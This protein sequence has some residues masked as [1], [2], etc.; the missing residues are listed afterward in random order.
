MTINVFSFFL[1]LYR[2]SFLQ[3]GSF[4]VCLYIILSSLI[5]VTFSLGF[6]WACHMFSLLCRIN[7]TKKQRKV[8]KA[9]SCRINI[10][11]DTS[12]SQSI[13]SIILLTIHDDTCINQASIDRL[14]IFSNTQPYS[15]TL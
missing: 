15:S 12:M 4:I 3:K 9:S 11:Y 10:Y 5:V 2:E 1:S 6:F 8:Q 13:S 14:D 7:R